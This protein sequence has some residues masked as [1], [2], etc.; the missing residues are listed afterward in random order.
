ME[1]R[2]KFVDL[3]EKRVQRAIKDIQLIGNLS[4]KNSYDYN[5]RDVTDLFNLLNEAVS[6]SKSRFQKGLVRLSKQG[7]A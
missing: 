1:K 5:G 7:G 2:E 6:H 3:A 4:N